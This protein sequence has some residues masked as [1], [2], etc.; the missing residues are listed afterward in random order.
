MCKWYYTIG[1]GIS[2]L[3]STVMTKGA[4]TQTIETLLVQRSG[5]TEVKLKF[6]PY[7]HFK[8]WITN[9]QEL[10]FVQFSKCIKINREK[11]T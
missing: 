4:K 1:I 11:N 9:F 2:I 6:S 7:L 8:L 10:N 5:K 3:T